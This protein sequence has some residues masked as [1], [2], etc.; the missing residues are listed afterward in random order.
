MCHDWML[1]GMPRYPIIVGI[2]MMP[3][4]ACWLVPRGVIIVPEVGGENGCHVQLPVE[5]AE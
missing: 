3:T 1:A 5:F 4:T 2:T